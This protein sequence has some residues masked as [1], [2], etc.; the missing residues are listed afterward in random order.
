MRR[1]QSKK[2]QPNLRT[3]I[4]LLGAIFAAVFLLAPATATSAQNTSSAPD[5][6]ETGCNVNNS[7]GS[8]NWLDA[9]ITPIRIA[10]YANSNTRA[11][12]QSIPGGSLVSGTMISTASTS[13]ADFTLSA[14]ELTADVMRANK[15]SRPPA[16]TDNSQHNETT[17]FGPED[18]GDGLE[19]AKH[20]DSAA[21]AACMDTADG[22]QDA[23]TSANVADGSVAGAKIAGATVPMTDATERSITTARI[24]DGTISTVGKSVSD[25]TTI[26][27]ANNS[28]PSAAPEEPTIG[29]GQTPPASVKVEE[30][31]P[32]SKVAAT[33]SAAEKASATGHN[34]MTA[35]TSLLIASSAKAF[36]GV[37]SAIELAGNFETL[38]TINGRS[39]TTARV[40]TG[41]DEK[42]TAGVQAI[43]RGSKTDDD[44]LDSAIVAPNSEG[45]DAGVKKALAQ[46][47]QSATDDGKY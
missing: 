43:L 17:T 3:L 33:T 11:T 13:V 5:C 25:V 6:G 32:E 24:L 4:D 26:V 27:L 9:S 35:A 14:A 31:T 46:S 34:S 47:T 21:K 29:A 19:A 42:L 45:L 28:P 44:G 12:E 16:N 7:A 20:A 1:D 10:D 39:V 37:V 2:R 18:P 15:P 8:A 38:G 23:L 36:N 41:H 30:N 22:A 40:D